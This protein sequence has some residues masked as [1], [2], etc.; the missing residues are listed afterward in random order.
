MDC[1]IALKIINNKEEME[2][3]NLQMELG[4][5]LN[6]LKRYTNNKSK[7]HCGLFIYLLLLWNIRGLL[8][9]LH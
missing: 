8:A 2:I 1:K 3:L 5:V 9:L 4:V 7:E 6:F